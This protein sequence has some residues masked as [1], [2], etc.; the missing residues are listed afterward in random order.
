MWPVIS[1]KPQLAGRFINLDD[2]I[3]FSESTVQAYVNGGFAS[4]RFFDSTK[5]TFTH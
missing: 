3:V 1:S 5:A 2:D 4:G